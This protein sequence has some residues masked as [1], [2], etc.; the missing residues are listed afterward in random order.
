MWVLGALA[1]LGAASGAWFSFGWWVPASR[2]YVKEEIH[3]VSII[4]LQGQL[5][6]L[7]SAKQAVTR[8]R[9]NVETALRG[10]KDPAFIAL[11][12]ERLSKAEDESKEIDDKIAD[13]A[14]EIKRRQQP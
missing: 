6:T 8:E 7:K 1:L 13:V 2:Q 10:A 5:Y 12:R 4:A 9:S 11:A 14:A 3:P